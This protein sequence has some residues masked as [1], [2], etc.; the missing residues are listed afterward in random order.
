MNWNE[1]EIPA[2]DA[3]WASE[4]IDQRL[5]RPLQ[6]YQ[7]LDFEAEFAIIDKFGIRFQALQKFTG[8]L[9]VSIV[10]IPEGGYMFCL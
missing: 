1:L 2:F 6:R 3:N 7:N 9:L 5:W 10:K 8:V 4:E